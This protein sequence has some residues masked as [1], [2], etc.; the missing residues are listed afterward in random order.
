MVLRK[1][2][3]NIQDPKDGK[4]APKM[5]G[6]YLIDLEVGKGAYWLPSIE[7]ILLPRSWNTIL[8]KAYFV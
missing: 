2:F 6:H 4:L 8:L 3:Q 5:E 7:G 1:S